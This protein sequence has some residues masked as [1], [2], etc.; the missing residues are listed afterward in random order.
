MKLSDRAEAALDFLLMLAIGL[1]LG[2][3]LFYWW[4]CTIC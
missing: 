1:V 4:S 2:L 3:S